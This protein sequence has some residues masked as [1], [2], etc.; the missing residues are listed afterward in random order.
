[1]WSPW[2]LVQ[3]SD[4]SPSRQE[5]RQPEMIQVYCNDPQCSDRQVLQTVKDPDETAIGAVWSGSTLFA[6]L[7]AALDT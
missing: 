4:S 3:T 2:I 1:M 5:G 7:P 6:I